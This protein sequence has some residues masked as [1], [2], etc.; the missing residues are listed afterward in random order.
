[1]ALCARN[2]PELMDSPHKGPV[3]WIMMFTVTVMIPRR[4][5]ISLEDGR[6]LPQG[7]EGE[8]LVRGDVIMLGYYGNQRATD[9]SLDKD[10]WYYTGQSH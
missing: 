4:Q 9:E 5:I 10:G 1:M 7:E 3:M 8:V 2:P 6:E